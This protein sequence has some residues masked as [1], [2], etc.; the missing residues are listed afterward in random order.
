MDCFLYNPQTA[1]GTRMRRPPSA[2]MTTIRQAWQLGRAQLHRSPSP[3]LD[4]RLLLAHV[5]GR[6]HAYLVAHDD[7]ALTAAQA[8]AYRATCWPAP[9]PTNP[10]PI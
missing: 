4:A 1:A 5:L 6:D 3:A 9:R 7:E 2:V 10:S 8:A